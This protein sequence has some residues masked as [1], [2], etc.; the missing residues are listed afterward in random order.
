LT[1]SIQAGIL[2]KK[3]WGLE[4][5]SMRLKLS[6]TIVKAQV[7]FLG[8]IFLTTSGLSQK[9]QEGFAIY[10]PSREISHNE[11]YKLISEK[12]GLKIDKIKLKNEPLISDNDLI[13]YY[14]A[15]HTLE[16]SSAAAKRIDEL[17]TGILVLI[18]VGKK[19][20]YWAA[21][22]SG[23]LSAGFGGVVVIKPDPFT[24][25]KDIIQIQCGYPSE[26]WFRGKDPRSDPEIIEAL[27]KSGKL[28]E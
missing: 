28:K 7:L 26:E 25:N 15:S 10:L 27:K 11:L 4:D 23:I 19:P 18:C 16:L 13:A 9:T 24:S 14:L 21:I 2:K 3:V 20:I 22:W 17:Y 1:K 5:E 8:F 12:N 6:G